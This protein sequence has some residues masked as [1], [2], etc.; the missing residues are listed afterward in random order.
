MKPCLAGIA[1]F[2]FVAT[3]LCAQFTGNDNSSGET[4][5]FAAALILPTNLFGASKTANPNRLKVSKFNAKTGARAGELWMGTRKALWFG[6]LVQTGGSVRG[7]GF[8]L[9]PQTLG[10]GVQCLSGLTFLT[11]NE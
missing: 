9:L 7:H 3:P 11:P 4:E 1:G 10:S 5:N 2:L 8:F 6:Q